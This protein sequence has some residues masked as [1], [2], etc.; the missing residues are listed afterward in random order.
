[1]SSGRN[2]V[3]RLAPRRLIELYSSIVKRRRKRKAQGRRYQELQLGKLLPRLEEGSFADAHVKHA[4]RD[5]RLDGNTQVT[6]LRTYFV[7]NFAK[8]ALHFSDGGDFVTGGVS[9]GTAPKIAAELLGH[10]GIGRKWWLIDPLD[11]RPDYRFPID[12][13][14]VTKDWRGGFTVEWINDLL[15]DGLNEISLPVA[16]VHL[17]SGNFDAELASLEALRG[18]LVSGGF[19]V[20]DQYGWVSPR[21]QKAFDDIIDENEWQSFVLPTYQLVVYRP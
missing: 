14:E 8:L 19:M 18:R 15:P 12:M 10:E 4:S 20:V 7:Y 6:R 5:P 11:G 3:L 9:Y 1:M 21:A 16:F 2:L 13:S 17:N